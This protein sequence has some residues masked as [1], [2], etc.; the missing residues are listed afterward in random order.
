MHGD[1]KQSASPLLTTT[2]QERKEMEINQE[3]LNFF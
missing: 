3:A 1:N 2:K